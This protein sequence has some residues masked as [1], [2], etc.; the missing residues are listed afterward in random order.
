MGLPEGGEEDA[1]VVRVDDD[2]DGTDRLIRNGHREFF[3][4]SIGFGVD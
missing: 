1:W 4:P 2:V 3:L